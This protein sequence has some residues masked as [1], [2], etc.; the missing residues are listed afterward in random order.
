MCAE[1]LCVVPSQD[2]AALWAPLSE[3]SD[4]SNP[5]WSLQAGWAPLGLSPFPLYTSGAR[6]VRTNH[7]LLTVYPCSGTASRMSSSAQLQPASTRPW[8]GTTKL[9]AKPLCFEK[10][11][12]P[13]PPTAAGS[14]D[15]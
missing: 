6:G 10:K 14:K 12:S 3:F 13:E 9:F 7:P 8:W 15:S 11:T 2:M 1:R 5:D 4:W